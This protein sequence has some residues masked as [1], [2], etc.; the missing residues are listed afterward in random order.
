MLIMPRSRVPCDS[1][2]NV[3]FLALGIEIATRE[4]G[5]K[6]VLHTSKCWCSRGS[7]FARSAGKVSV[8]RCT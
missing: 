3:C 4:K 6:M 5:M 1:A 2:V 8:A 7:K